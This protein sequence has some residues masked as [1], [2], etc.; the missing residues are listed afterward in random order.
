MGRDPLLSKDH[1]A[2]SFA[3]FRIVYLVLSVRGDA[4]VRYGAERFLY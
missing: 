3:G 4:T 1:E 2:S